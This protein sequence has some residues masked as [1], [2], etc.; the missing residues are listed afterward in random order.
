[1]RLGAVSDGDLRQLI[2]LG[3]GRHARTKTHSSSVHLAETAV[4]HA[5]R[6]EQRDV[7]QKSWR[8][9]E[10]EVKLRPFGTGLSPQFAKLK[11]QLKLE[12]REEI[13]REVMEELVTNQSRTETST[14]RTR[15]E[16]RPLQRFKTRYD[17]LQLQTDVHY[18]ASNAS[19]RRAR[20][21]LRQRDPKQKSIR[22]RDGEEQR[23]LLKSSRLR[24]ALRPAST[25]SPARARKEIDY[26]EYWRV[27]SAAAH[28]AIEKQRQSEQV[29]RLRLSRWPK[30]YI[31]PLSNELMEGWDPDK[32][33]VEDIFGRTLHS[34]RVW[35][36]N[37]LS[38]N[39]KDSTSSLA[40]WKN[41]SRTRRLTMAEHVRDTNHY[42]FVRA[43]VYRLWKSKRYRTLDPA[44]ADLF[45][46]PIL[47]LPKRGKFITA[48]C[49]NLTAANVAAA[50]PHFN[51]AT[52]HKHLFALSKEHY[53][54]SKCFGWWADPTG[55][56]QHA[57][58]LSY[59][60][61]QPE[62]L[63]VD[64]Y[65]LY[66][67][68]HAGV[69]KC[70]DLFKFPG[71]PEYPNV[72]SAP[73]ISNVHWPN[74][75]SAGTP[76]WADETGDRPFRMLFLGGVSHGDTRVRKRVRS[77]CTSYRD[78]RKCFVQ[79]YDFGSLL[80]KYKSQFCLEPAGDSPF[81]RSTTDSIAFGCIPVF[82]SGP[83]E[84]AYNWLWS[85]WRQAASVRVNRTLY[86]AGKIDL[87]RLLHSIPPELV[88][89]MRQTLAQYGRAFTMSLEDDP[90]D[91]VHML[92]HGAV[93]TAQRLDSIRRQERLLG[94]R[95]E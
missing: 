76:P 94:G 42:G 65:Y 24:T 90:G 69:P 2:Q 4:M 39:H 3:H 19:L 73:Y 23:P 92:V 18:E 36:S 62:R 29:A 7:P 13:K 20:I 61:I 28:D 70:N 86:L 17:R 27:A 6:A 87:H 10:E 32:S 74:S 83:Q 54:G 37:A 25:D 85:G 72:E 63:R 40:W 93:E 91:E 12:L 59:S 14:G 43:L 80:L 51:S 84:E 35:E 89:S 41:I 95:R 16:V 1:M 46:V 47:P 79:R 49:L 48:A 31:Y 78:A 81:R 67:R 30:V 77:A 34:M 50:L 8:Q 33:S 15:K 5:R 64:D 11:E 75:A 66:E 58:R 26:D 88:I 57:Q 45:L 82:F 38:R 56:F 21:Q 71:C 44:E 60:T 22:I 53:E 9:L 52:A 55:L 68:K